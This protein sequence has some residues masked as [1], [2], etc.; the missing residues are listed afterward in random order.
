MCSFG[1]ITFKA[2]VA[3]MQK[4]IKWCCYKYTYI[5]F[6]LLDLKGGRQGHFPQGHFPQVFL[7]PIINLD[8]AEI[9]YRITEL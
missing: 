4:I 7:V 2:R 9:K 6:L 1:F 5:K 8:G 3:N